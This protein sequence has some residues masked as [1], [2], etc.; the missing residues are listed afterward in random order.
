MGAKNG[1][2]WRRKTGQKRR[3]NG[4]SV[5]SI[6]NCPQ[7]NRAQRNAEKELRLA[8]RRHPDKSARPLRTHCP[9]STF[10]LLLHGKISPCSPD[11]HGTNRHVPNL[12]PQHAPFAFA[13]FSV[14]C[15]I[16][17]PIFTF[18]RSARSIAARHRLQRL[19]LSPHKTVSPARA[20]P[21]LETGGG[22]ELSADFRY[23]RCQQ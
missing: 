4:S 5:H 6:R 17:S 13:T 11:L 3:G 16:V 15:T 22:V 14:F 10:S 9:Q 1:R 20:V 8:F 12:H 23:N 18:S 7:I 21:F 19:N 2:F